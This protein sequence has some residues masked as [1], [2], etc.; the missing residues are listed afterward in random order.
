MFF[1]LF[2]EV[3]LKR[4]IDPKVLIQQIH[5]EFDSADERLLKEALEII[6]KVKIPEIESIEQRANNRL[7]LGFSNCVEVQIFK[8]VKT[9]KT[10]KEKINQINTAVAQLITNYRHYYPLLKFLTINELDR[11]C[12]K[13]NLLYAPVGKY[14]GDIPDKNVLDI[15]NAKELSYADSPKNHTIVVV[16]P[17]NI[18]K[19]CPKDIAKILTSGFETTL[20]HGPYSTLEDYI[21]NS[22]IEFEYHKSPGNYILH[23]RDRYS[24]K[25]INLS[26]LFIA[27]PKSKFDLSGLTKDGKGY[28]KVK[29]TEYDD[30]IVFRYVKGGIQ[31]LTKWGLEASDPLLLNEI[32]N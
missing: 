14:I 17:D 21:R 1:K 29:I 18:K 7:S 20:S 3:F 5:D 11:I 10:E 30:P 22:A 13:Y 32:E 26:G 25:D 27:A 9:N 16:Y 12:N 28:H 6:N 4:P 24:V 8:E 31:V 19:E 23:F 2:E 15:K